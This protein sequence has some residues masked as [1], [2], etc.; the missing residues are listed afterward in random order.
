MRTRFPCRWP[1]LIRGSRGYESRIRV[2]TVLESF[3]SEACKTWTTE[4]TVKRSQ[5]KAVTSCNVPFQ[6]QGRGEMFGFFFFWLINMM[7]FHVPNHI[8]VVSKSAFFVWNLLIQT[9]K[10][11]KQNRDAQFWSP[12]AFNTAWNNSWP[13]VS[14][15]ACKMVFI[16]ALQADRLTSAMCCQHSARHLHH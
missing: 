6:L 5:W 4:E 11:N 15:D 1:K 10:P 13:G 7:S 3:I 9:K 16:A 14:R 12:G 2:G 8:Q